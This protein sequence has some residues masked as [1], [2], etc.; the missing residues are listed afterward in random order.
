M[1][2]AVA[3]TSP[4]AL[5]C[6]FINHEDWGTCWDTGDEESLSM[7]WYDEHNWSVSWRAGF[8]RSDSIRRPY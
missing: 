6:Q 3:L 1:A 7:S 8:N 5:V 4:A 2:M